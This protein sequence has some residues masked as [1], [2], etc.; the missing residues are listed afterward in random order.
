M[1]G[2]DDDSLRKAWS[3]GVSVAAIA[4]MN[5][6]SSGAVSTLVQELSLPNRDAG[7]RLLETRAEPL[8]GRIVAPAGAAALA[9]AEAIFC[10]HRGVSGAAAG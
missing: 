6:T 5:R 3:D 4:R 9:E 1:D 7:G 10:I 8:Q 2:R